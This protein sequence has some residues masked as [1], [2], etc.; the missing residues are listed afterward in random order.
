[1][2]TFRWYVLSPG[3]LVFA[4]IALFFILFLGWISVRDIVRPLLRPTAEEPRSEAFRNTKPLGVALGLLILFSPFLALSAWIWFRPALL[5]THASG[6][7][8]VRNAFLVAR[9]F[10]PA[11]RPRVLSADLERGTDDDGT[12]YEHIF[13]GTIRLTFPPE[14]GEPEILLHATA[15]GDDDAGRPAIYR[16]L[17]LDRLCATTPGNPGRFVTPMFRL[18]AD[19][20]VAVPTPREPAR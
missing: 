9:R 1:M 15:M 20:P 19:G 18:S 6:D 12:P 13:S 7:W 17:G 3:D 10:I 14:T 4:G 16:D 8:A 11:G 5:T 2:P